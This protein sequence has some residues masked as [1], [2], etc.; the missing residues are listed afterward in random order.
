V[1]VGGKLQIRAYRVSKTSVTLVHSNT[2]SGK[3][4]DH[5]MNAVCSVHAKGEAHLVV[6]GDSRGRMQVTQID[7]ANSP[8]S[9]VLLSQH[10]EGM[11]SRPTLSLSVAC[12]STCRSKFILIAGNTAGEVRFC[13]GNESRARSYFHTRRASSVSTAVNLTHYPNPFRDSLRS[14]QVGIFHLTHDKL[15]SSLSPVL[16]RTYK[17]H[18]I[19]ANAVACEF[20]SGILTVVSGGDDQALSV[21]QFSLDD[22]EDELTPLSSHTLANASTSAI[23]STMIDASGDSI[24]IY[25]IGYDQRLASWDFTTEPTASITQKFQPAVVTVTDVSGADIVPSLRSPDVNFV[26]VVGDGVEILSVPSSREPQLEIDS[27]AVNSAAKLLLSATYVLVTTGAGIGKDSGLKTFEEMSSDYRELCDPSALC[28]SPDKFY[29]FWE[30]FAQQYEDAPLHDG[31]MVLQRLV[32][33]GEGKLPKLESS[34]CYTSNVDGMMRR[35][36]G[37]NDGEKVCEIHGFAGEWRCG[38]AM[39]KTL[40]GDKRMGQ[41]WAEWNERA[42]RCGSSPFLCGL[43]KEEV[44]DKICSCCGLANRPNVLMFNDTDSNVLS[45]IDKAREN[46]QRWEQ[47]MEDNVV[48]A[49]DGAKSLVILELGC[50]VNVPSVRN[51]GYE[52]IKD[53]RSRGGRAHLIRVNLKD[54]GHIE[55]RDLDMDEDMR[56]KALVSIKGGAKDTMVVIEAAIER[57]L[58]DG[59]EGEEEEERDLVFDDSWFENKEEEVLQEFGAYGVDE[60]GHEDGQA[61]D[62]VR[63]Q[64]EEVRVKSLMSTD[65]TMVATPKGIAKKEAKV[66][67][68]SDEVEDVEEEEGSENEGRQL[69]FDDGWDQAKEEEEEDKTERVLEVD[70]DWGENEEDILE[71]S[72]S[73]GTFKDDEDVKEKHLREEDEKERREEEERLQEEALKREKEEKA[74]EE[75]AEKRELFFED[76]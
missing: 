8:K 20:T 35:L 70:D 1:A 26:A 68:G 51:E 34:Y 76:F 12:V 54:E 73:F 45:D 11:S 9:P 74:K 60:D 28:T 19:G 59:E 61:G 25:T 7:L 58:E 6:T 14:S 5:R 55:G 32:G 67:E 52:V 41:M 13:V 72:Q 29:E 69:E 2:D 24:T 65:I 18:Q 75:E 47:T 31:Y 40:G 16:L 49:G 63:K 57:M 38:G 44:G 10:I 30:A 56:R 36:P 22:E 27:R 3:E 17:P 42:E 71:K 50:G 62:D 15:S 66:L 37:F 53:L 23:K 33:E 43:A 64:L 4:M 39:G 21:N 46:Y 48:G